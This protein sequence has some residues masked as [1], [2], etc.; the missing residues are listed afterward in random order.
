M[1]AGCCAQRYWGLRRSLALTFRAGG[2]LL[3]IPWRCGAEHRD[4]MHTVAQQSDPLAPLVSRSSSLSIARACEDRAESVGGSVAL[5]LYP[6]RSRAPSA[7][8]NDT[9]GRRRVRRGPC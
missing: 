9:R 8:P 7:A 5:S 6:L 4:D 1:A 3:F 2:M